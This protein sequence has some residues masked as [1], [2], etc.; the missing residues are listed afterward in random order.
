M[1]KLTEAKFTYIGHLDSHTVESCTRLV[2][3][4]HR[5]SWSVQQPAAIVW[6]I[7]PSGRIRGIV[8]QAARNI[9]PTSFP[10]LPTAAHFVCALHCW[11]RCPRSL[12]A[13]WPLR[14]SSEF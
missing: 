6:P 14:V 9:L 8:F 5:S 3:H 13:G 4:L 10:G 7:A 1:E 2:L 12:Y 11:R